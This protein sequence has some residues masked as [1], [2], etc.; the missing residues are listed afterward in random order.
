M[1]ENVLL[2]EVKTLTRINQDCT[3]VN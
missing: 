3:L 2:L 1:I